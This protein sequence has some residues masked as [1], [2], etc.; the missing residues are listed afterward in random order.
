LAEI[1]S[2]LDIG[3]LYHDL[4]FSYQRAQRLYHGS[5]G[6]NYVLQSTLE[7]LL[8][9]EAQGKL[10]LANSQTFEQ[11]ITKFE[12]FLKSGKI[13]HSLSLQEQDEN[14]Y[15]LRVEGCVFAGKVH[16]LANTKDVTCPYAVIAMALFNKYKGKLPVEKESFYF[17]HGTQ[18]VIGAEPL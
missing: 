16:K 14:Q 6:S 10:Q 15:V 13:V 5:R 9:I 17:E 1:N 11:A 8:R 18:T 7:F 12:E 3:T 2:I 4:L